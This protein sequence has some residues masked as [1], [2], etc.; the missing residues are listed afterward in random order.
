M[1]KETI[2]KAIWMQKNLDNA[3]KYLTD[4]YSSKDARFG[5]IE[6]HPKFYEKDPNI[7]ASYEKILIE[8][9]HQMQLQL[10]NLTD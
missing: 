3:K 10:D 8:Y 6:I 2:N 1:K 4:F 5:V 9:V 7:L